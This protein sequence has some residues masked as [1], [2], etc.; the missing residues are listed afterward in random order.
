MTS[1]W[2]RHFEKQEYKVLKEISAGF[3]PVLC[4]SQSAFCSS[5]VKALQNCVK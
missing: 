1:M 3:E 2:N 5:W 4:N